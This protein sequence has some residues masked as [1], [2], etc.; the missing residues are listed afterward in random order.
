MKKVF[1]ILS[2]FSLLCFTGC[3]YKTSRAKKVELTRRILQGDKKALQE[4]DE[5]IQKVKA[6][7]KTDPEASK[8]LEEWTN[9]SLEEINASLK[10]F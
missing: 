3:G 5:I 4:R 1:Y 8:E 2:I 10:N 6:K 9:V 7:A